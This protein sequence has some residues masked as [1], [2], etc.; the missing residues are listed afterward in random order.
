MNFVAVDVETANCNRA[1]ICQIGMVSYVDGVEMERWCSLVNPECC[2]ESMNIAVHGIRESDVVYSP[3]LPE[4]I[5]EVRRLMENRVVVCHSS[6]D[7]TAF[8]GAFKKYD[9]PDLDCTWLD[10]VRVARRAWTEY[11]GTGYGLRN[12]ADKLGITFQHHDALED[13]R[14]AGEILI[15]AVQDTGIALDDWIQR[16]E[17]PVKWQKANGVMRR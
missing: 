2:F 14:A 11:S 8:A 17:K 9:L 6:F 1:S 13:A 12:L 3:C 15:R 16:V 7:R 4:I 5:D 10:S